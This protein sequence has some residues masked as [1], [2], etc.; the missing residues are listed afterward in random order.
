[1]REG[2]HCFNKGWFQLRFRRQL[3]F[4]NFGLHKFEYQRKVKRES[5]DHSL[6]V[7]IQK[8]KYVVPK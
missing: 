2:H 4:S 3:V 1:M 6:K 5:V 8:Y 7:H